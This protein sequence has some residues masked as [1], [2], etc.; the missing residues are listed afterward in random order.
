MPHTSGLELFK[1]NANRYR[2]LNVRWPLVA[3]AA[4]L[5]LLVLA[6]NAWWL[7]AMLSRPALE[8]ELEEIARTSAQRKQVAERIRE[9]SGGLDEGTAR[10]REGDAAL[11]TMISLDKEARQAAAGVDADGSA[12]ADP[13]ALL[14]RME[15]SDNFLRALSKRV[16]P[17]RIDAAALGSLLS[18]GPGLP[19]S[20]PDAWPVRGVV[21]SEFG[22]RLSP[23]AGQ[24]EFH[25]GVDIM[26]PAGTPVRAPAPGLVSFAG[27]DSEGNMTVVLD[28]GGGYVTAF[29]HMQR[30]DV[31]A[32]ARVERGD[33]LGG[34][35]QDGRSTGPHLH[36]EIRFAG[37]PV[38]PAAYLG[39]AA[40][41]PGRS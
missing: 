17:R 4:A 19:G 25:K 10:L 13:K 28:H 23:F 20:V 14:D 41:A 12:A 6:G 35:G 7:T 8:E 21:S 5:C 30:L 9:I 1:D 27:E 11:R 40:P 24:E 31:R 38:N 36:Y 2:R 18:V 33:S 16:E 29:S 26:A 39:G 32:G 22:V 34:V 37:V 15:L 3:A